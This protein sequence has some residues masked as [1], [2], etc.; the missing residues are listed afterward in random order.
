MQS[1]HF[2]LWDYHVHSRLCGHAVGKLS[3]YVQHA[4]DIGL[5]EIGLSDHFPMFFLPPEANAEQYAMKRNKFPKYLAECNRLKQKFSHQISIKIASEVD[6]FPD[7]A[8][9]ERLLPELQQYMGDLDYLIGSIHIVK[10]DD[11]PPF[12]VDSPNV[13]D[14]FEK[15]GEETIFT[16]YYRGLIQLVKSDLYQIVGHCDLPKK[17]GRY[18]GKSDAIWEMKLKFLDELKKNSNMA[19]EINHSGLYKPVKEQYP[20]DEMIQ[21]IIERGIPIVFGSDAHKPKDVGYK[22]AQTLEKCRKF[23]Q[24]LDKPL[25]LAQFTHRKMEK[26]VVE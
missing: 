14:Y 6:F 17:Y 7:S 10:I 8:T 23:A 3:A 13:F 4:V 24:T 5:Q 11:D 12:A 20:H 26:I 16:E 21:A 22:F 1:N 9:M 25:I 19:V 15:Y 18:F 2:R